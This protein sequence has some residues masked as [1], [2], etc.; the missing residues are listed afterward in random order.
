MEE[1]RLGYGTSG[2]EDDDAEEASPRP[3]AKRSRVADAALP[4]AGM[5]LLPPPSDVLKLYGTHAVKTGAQTS[6]PGL[7]RCHSGVPGQPI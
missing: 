7:H 3:P 6:F 5:S 2:S 1:L 4:A